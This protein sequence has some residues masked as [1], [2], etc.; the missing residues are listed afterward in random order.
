V[1]IGQ[2]PAAAPALTCVT[3]DGLDLAVYD[4]GGA[5]D[6]LLLVHATGFCAGVLLPLARSLGDRFH[7]WALDLR[8]HG[9]SGRPADGDFTW[10]GFGT[11]VLTCVDRLGLVRPVAFGHSCGGAALL[12]AEQAR[13][14]TFRSLY[15]FE[16]VVIPDQPGPVAV[17]DN[18]L[19]RGARRR[20]ETFP[21]AEDAF[22]NFSAKPPFDRLDPDVLLR[23]VEDGFEV[24]PADEG[25]D[26]EEIRLRCRREDEAEVYLLGFGNGVYPRLHEVRCPVTL[27]YG[28]KTDAFGT[29]I[30]AAD[31]AR[32]PDATLDPFDDLG[33]FGPLQR[34]DEVADRVRTVLSLPGGT[35]RS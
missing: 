11:D 7:C 16:P 31:A 35:P 18:P 22:A 10:T 4:F 32:L 1:P 28:R 19:T 6:D 34:P 15:L 25:G 27:A 23:Y 17:A 29:R 2:D 8:G 12:L 3:P 24:V 5:G 20:R 9:R 13:H 14:G 26:G 21:S 33:H 30:M